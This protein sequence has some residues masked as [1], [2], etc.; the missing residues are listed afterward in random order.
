MNL[1]INESIKIKIYAKSKWNSTLIEISENEEYEFNAIGNWK[2]LFIT[3]D[4]DGFTCLYMQLF[5]SVKR[6][7]RHKWFSLI[8]SLNQKKD[9]Y[10]LIGKH[11]IVSFKNCG[12]LYCFA[13]DVNRF[14]WNNFGYLTLHI[15]RIN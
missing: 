6:A 9:S 2:D 11:N 8:G 5:N 12:N 15:K 7:K 14:Y 1:K 13:N 10:F 3:T 4:A